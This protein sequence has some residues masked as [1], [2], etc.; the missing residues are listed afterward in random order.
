M[1]QSDDNSAL[2]LGLGP[3]GMLTTLVLKR[4]GFAVRVSSAEPEDHPRARLLRSQ[5]IDYSRS[6]SGSAGLIIEA[7]GSADFA[8]AALRCLAPCGVFVTLGAQSAAGEF[9]FIDLIVGNQTIVGSVNGSRESFEAALSD[10]AAFDASV[11]R[12]MIRRFAFGDY[13][14]TLL[15]P[16]GEEPKF[17]HV[18]AD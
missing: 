10:L 12:A 2:V 7:A 15:E 1:R 14:R 17:V 3:I 16:S 4:R 18:I 9:S 13:R 8:L 5:G 11:L 6:L